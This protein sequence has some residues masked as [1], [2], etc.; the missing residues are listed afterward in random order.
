MS[1]RGLRRAFTEPLIGLLFREGTGNASE[2]KENVAGAGL[3]ESTEAMKPCTFAI[4]AM[5]LE[6]LADPAPSPR[7]SLA[8]KTDALGVISIALY[9]Q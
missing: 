9:R 3:A 2:L 8:T 6:R 1:Q 4:A 7:R 5:V